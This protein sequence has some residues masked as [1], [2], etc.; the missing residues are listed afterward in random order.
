[1][2]IER[3]PLD[4]LELRRTTQQSQ[5]TNWSAIEGRVKTLQE[6][7]QELDEMGEFLKKSG[8]SSDTDIMTVT[9]GATAEAAS[10]TVI[11][12]Q[13]AANAV[14][15]HQTGWADANSTAVNSSGGNKSFSYDY[16]G[17][18]VTV[19]VPDGTTLLGLVNL[20]NR[21]VNN[22]GVTASIV[23]DG[24]GGG[25]D[26]HLVLTGN[27]TGAGN[28]VTVIDTGGNPTDI[29][30][31]G[32]EFDEANWDV[33]Q[34]AQ[35]AQIKVDG[36]PDAGW[37]FSWIES[38]SNDVEDVIPGVTL[39]L[40]DDSGGNP[41]QI[42]IGLDK[43]SIAA[44][45]RSLISAFNDVI[46]LINTT[47][48]YNS[49]DETSA[50]LTGDP[51]ARQLRSNLMNLLADNIPGTDTADVYRSLGQV[52]LS[53]TSGGEITLDETALDEALDDDALAVAR[54]FAFDAAG[55]SSF[56]TVT[57]H[58]ENTVG[59]SYAFTV[60]YD[61]SGN[62]DPS[63]ANTIG[64]YNA[65]IHGDRLLG[66]ATGSEV[67][68]LLLT[69]S[70]PGDGPNSLSGTVKVYT[71]LSTLLSNMIEDMTDSIEGTFTINRE[72]LNDSI[73]LLDEQIANW[74]K[75]LEQIEATYTRRFSQMETLI[76]QLQ[77]QSN[78]LSAIG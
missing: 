52:G 47:T 49:E 12:N 7:A 38:A 72:R 53:L 69:F 13:L 77:T 31:T 41:I 37:A 63:G 66:G 4:L 61:A 62:I 44:N 22:P 46:K 14:H 29:G 26:Y 48:R 1:M 10:H 11:I 2:E 60:T 35:N 54:L 28:D 39:H 5:L 25:S 43:E 15:A 8:T 76:S 57:G 58:G 32:A 40:L 68:G 59:G 67:E 23:N 30:S 17:T 18:T 56:V 45:V 24:T 3:H 19:T 34:A 50:P 73:D 16:A 51:L 78:Y 75:R 42:D 64:G 27:E 21:D 55:T 20:I 9:A 74:E 33:T 70:D 65:I 71:G 6:K 36:I